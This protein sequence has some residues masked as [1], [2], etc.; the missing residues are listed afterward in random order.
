MTSDAPP[1]PMTRDR[2]LNASALSHDQAVVDAYVNDPLV[3]RGPIPDR[4]AMTEMRKQLPGLAP[5]IKL[6]ILIMAG[7]GSPMGDGSR[8]QALYE[9]VGSEDK[10]LK[11]YEGLYH[12]IF[13][14]PEHPQVMADIE[15]WLDTH[16]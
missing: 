9:A 1:P 12:E 3:Y 16:M 14:E 5:G 6:P 11:L 4:S 2:V 13:N 8:S 10:T 7:A 15:A